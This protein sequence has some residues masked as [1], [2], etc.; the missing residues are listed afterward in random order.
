M[1]SGV[2][3]VA[4]MS[5]APKLIVQVL[6]SVYPLTHAQKVETKRA[7]GW[8]EHSPFAGWLFKYIDAVNRE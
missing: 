6:P 4:Q 7:G 5:A 1:Y 2:I 3:L 8:L